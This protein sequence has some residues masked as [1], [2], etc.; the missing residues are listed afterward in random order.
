MTQAYR[1]S[2]KEGYPTPL[3]SSAPFQA[4]S[5]ADLRLR[6]A[7]AAAPMAQPFFVEAGAILLEGGYEYAAIGP[8]GDT[9]TPWLHKSQLIPPDHA[10]K[11]WA[12]A[13]VVSAKV[14][15]QKYGLA[16]A[17]T[18]VREIAGSAA[19]DIDYARL[20]AEAEAFWRD[21]SARLREIGL[22]K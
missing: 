12:L 18:H 16:A 13:P 17:A 9:W 3:F 4:S 20:A 8:R 6:I 1:L 7:L 11:L 14:L 22:M 5:A 15:H 10:R 2:S 21:E 19:T